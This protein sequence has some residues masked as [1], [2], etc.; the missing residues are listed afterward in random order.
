MCRLDEE[1]SLQWN[2]EKLS[3]ATADAGRACGLVSKVDEDGLP[4]NHATFHDLRRTFAAGLMQWLP[5]NEVIALTRHSDPKVLLDFYVAAAVDE[6]SQK[7]LNPS[8]QN[9]LGGI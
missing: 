4:I 6:L 1:R 5:I 3:K 9:T 8:Q 2:A 7:L